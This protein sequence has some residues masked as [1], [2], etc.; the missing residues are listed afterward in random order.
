M[1]N[2]KRSRKDAFGGG[3]SGSGS[4]CSDLLSDFEE[5]VVLA[6]V[7]ERV[8]RVVWSERKEA[9]I[10]GCAMR[11][12][13]GKSIV[14]VEVSRNGWATALPRSNSVDDAVAV[15]L[16]VGASSRLVA[17]LSDIVPSPK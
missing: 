7:E 3:L 16:V 8:G 9:L 12:E 13:V 2:F 14:D 5:D 10:E 1:R 6:E 17:T 15:D 11:L 4:S